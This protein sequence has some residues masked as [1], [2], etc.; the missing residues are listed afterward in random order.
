MINEKTSY[1]YI[2]IL[3]LFKQDLLYFLHKCIKNYNYNCKMTVIILLV[4]RL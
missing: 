2:Q 3:L 1:H 4:F